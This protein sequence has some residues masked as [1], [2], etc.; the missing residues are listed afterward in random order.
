MC[1]NP[2]SLTLSDGHDFVSF[3]ISVQTPV[4]DEMN[5]DLEAKLTRMLIGTLT[6]WLPLTVYRKKISQLNKSTSLFL[7]LI[8]E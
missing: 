6:K 1:I 5:D 8:R 4:T 3:Y 7:S 2:P